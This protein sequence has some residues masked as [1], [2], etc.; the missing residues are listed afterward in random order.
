MANT[1]TLKLAFNHTP[2]FGQL[3]DIRRDPSR[4][5]ALP[6]SLQPHFPYR[7]LVVMTI[8]NEVQATMLKARISI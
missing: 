3:G 7:P 1:W 2:V 4:L 8:S 6:T 5:I